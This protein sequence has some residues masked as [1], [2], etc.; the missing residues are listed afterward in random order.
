M[1][2]PCSSSLTIFPF[3]SSITLFFLLLTI[4]ES[5]VAITTVVPALLI[6]SNKLTLETISGED[7]IFSTFGTG[8]ESVIRI[9]TFRSYSFHFI[10]EKP[11]IF[12]QLLNNYNEYVKKN[13]V[14]DLGSDYY[15]ADE[16]TVNTTKR[17]LSELIQPA[18]IIFF[19]PSSEPVIIP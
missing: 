18:I 9:N 15:W 1:Y 3:E 4:D 17:R 16:M 14:I 11:E 2:L 10:K 5:C 7:F 13:G 19:I 6:F 12:R 8:D